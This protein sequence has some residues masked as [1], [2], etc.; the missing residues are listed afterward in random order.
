MPR[1]R[2]CSMSDGLSI[3][4]AICGTSLVCAGLLS[5]QIDHRHLRRRQEPDGGT[6]RSRAAA[7]VNLCV[8]NVMEPAPH[9][10][11]E[12]NDEI[13]GVNLTAMRVSRKLQVKEP[14][15]GLLDGRPVL[16]E[17]N[18]TVT[19]ERCEKFP[20]SVFSASQPEAPPRRVV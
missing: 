3:L 12:I 15:G 8:A 2:M 20:L 4:S 6:P 7:H 10:E 13:E 17:K 18:E 1:D 19:G 14:P 5:D 16:E 9:R 11:V